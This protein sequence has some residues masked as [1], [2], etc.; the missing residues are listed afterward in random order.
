MI[1]PGSMVASVAAL[2]AAVVPFD[3]AGQSVGQVQWT[4]VPPSKTH[5]VLGD[6]LVDLDGDGR[7][8]VVRVVRGNQSAG[9]LVME[10][11][12]DGTLNVVGLAAGHWTDVLSMAVVPRVGLPA[13]II[14]TVRADPFQVRSLELAGKALDKVR[15]MPWPSRQ[16]VR[17]VA[18]V[19]GDGMLETLGASE[20][21]FGT[22]LISDYASGAVERSIAFEAR[23]VEPAQLDGDPALELILAY[24]GTLSRGLI[25]D[26]ATGEEEWSYPAG[27]R[28]GAR[29]GRLS[30][31]PLLRTFIAP[32]PAST[33][34]FSGAPYG[35]VQEFPFTVGL[36]ESALLD[37]DNDGIDEV[38]FTAF[39]PSLRWFDPVSGAITD[40]GTARQADLPANVGRIAPD[41]PAVALISPDEIRGGGFRVV[42]IASGAELHT[43]VAETGPHT[44][45][46]F[47]DPDGTGVDRIALA[48]LTNAAGQQQVTI[49]IL[50][51]ASGTLLDRTTLAPGLGSIPWPLAL[52]AGDFDGLPGDEIALYVSE[53]T[54]AM[55]HG[56]TLAERWR[57]DEPDNR[58][59]FPSVVAADVDGDGR[60][61]LLQGYQESTWPQPLRGL[62]ALTGAT[63]APIWD[64]GP[65]LTSIGLDLRVG[66]FDEVPGLEVLFASSTVH[67]FDAGT[68]AGK[69]EIAPVVLPL[70]L[71]GLTTWGEES[72]CRIGLL[73]GGTNGDSNRM[74]TFRCADRSLEATHWLPEGTQWVQAMDSQGS[75]WAMLAAGQVWLGGP[76]APST[77]VSDRYET[78]FA[79]ASRGRALRTGPDYVDGLFGTGLRLI[80]FRIADDRL[81][82][83]RFEAL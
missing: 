81:F 6:H 22:L 13:S 78:S 83:N 19:D 52:A 80:R 3:L 7:N 24:E 10:F 42:D 70:T 28:A 39:G 69:W 53:R 43:E 18:D 51:A 71:K 30:A 34:I 55:L 64:T 75:Q 5:S 38:F 76:G 31:D 11:A 74:Q 46:A 37:I 29:A 60:A 68:G 12:Q 65:V 14:V 62:R 16:R 36:G 21:A 50:D 9:L 82:A 67:A 48:T 66:D 56:Q 63:G 47:F 27:F 59:V 73:L 45:A 54:T 8:E 1:K 15:D 61:D 57:L 20:D 2:I 33:P 49:T 41:G 77:P 4:Y 79:V 35:I 40:Y 26:G 72:D 17:A 23:S 44:A 58:K 32:A 25:V